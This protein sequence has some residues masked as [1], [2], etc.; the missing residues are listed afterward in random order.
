LRAI[1][2]PVHGHIVH[3]GQETSSRFLIRA[4]MDVGG[5]STTAEYPTAEL[6]NAGRE[7]SR[8]LCRGAPGCYTL[9]PGGARWSVIVFWDHSS[10]PFRQFYDVY[11]HWCPRNG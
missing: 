8:A 5:F 1:P 3:P 9:H 4:P 7:V 2:I 11:F 6:S 10:R